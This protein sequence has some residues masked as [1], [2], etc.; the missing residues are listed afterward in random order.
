MPSRFS[1]LPCWQASRSRNTPSTSDLPPL[2]LV[3]RKLR[4]NLLGT[5]TSWKVVLARAPG[6]GTSAR[7]WQTEAEGG[8]FEVL[9][10]DARVSISLSEIMSHMRPYECG[11]SRMPCI[12]LLFSFP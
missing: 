4:P 7:E 11:M 6:E 12:A 1:S 10:M 9:D 5:P 8:Y 2:H 3:T